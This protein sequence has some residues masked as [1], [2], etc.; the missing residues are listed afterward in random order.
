MNSRETNQEKRRRWQE[1]LETQIAQPEDPL[2]VYTF[3]RSWNTSARPISARCIDKRDYIVKGQQAGRQIVNEQIVARLGIALNAPVGEPKIV[4]ISPDL[5]ELD[6]LFNY[7]TPGSAHATLFI[8]N[9]FD[10]RDLSKVY[11]D[12]PENRLRFALL[13]VLYG[14]VQA[15]DHQ[16]IFQKN[17]PNLVYSVDHGHFFPGG[18]NW[19]END[20]EQASA[21]TLDERLRS[22]C[23]FTTDTEEIQTALSQLSNITETQIIQAVAASP[24]EWDFTI[25]ERV[26]M[27]EYLIIRQGELVQLL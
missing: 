11:T 10:N 16:F 25:K 22:A 3:R 20:L 6:P 27:I 24:A 5:L 21:A 9:C 2:L 26:T 7:L 19:T 4:E 14:W 23:H 1:A 18:P 13:C 15:K 8:P 12:Q 17:R